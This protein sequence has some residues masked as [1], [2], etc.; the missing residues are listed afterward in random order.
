MNHF[1]CQEGE[2]CGAGDSQVRRCDIQGFDSIHGHFVEVRCVHITVIIP[3]ETIE[4]DQ[5]HLLFLFDCRSSKDGRGPEEAET[6]SPQHGEHRHFTGLYWLFP[7]AKMLIYKTIHLLASHRRCSEA[8][9][10]WA[11]F[12]Q[13]ILS[14]RLG[15]LYQHFLHAAQWC[16]W[17]NFT[18]G[19]CVHIEFSPC[20]ALEGWQ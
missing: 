13:L 1:T 16:L 14:G 2:V 10:F 4:G 11:K 20:F 12:H 9:S 5:Q 6:C 8:N 3:S 15:R 19:S 17:A 18:A 7:P